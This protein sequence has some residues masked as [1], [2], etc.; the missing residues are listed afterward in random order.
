MYSIVEVN[1]FD[2]PTFIRIFGSI[3]EHS[4]WVA[5]IAAAGRPYA[6]LQAL[7]AAMQDAVDAASRE[8]QLT[9]IRAHP[10]L[11]G[12]LAPSETAAEALTAESRSEQSSVGLDRCTQQELDQLRTF[13]QAY[14][15]KFGFPFIVAVRGLSRTEIIARLS[16]RLANSA[17]QEFRNNLVEIS[18]IASLRLAALVR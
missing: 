1:A 16:T 10:E 13:N 2:Q 9:L 3:Y 6:D 11:L 18:K 4:P 12:R 15:E 5:A 7:A 14:R 8:S 17:E